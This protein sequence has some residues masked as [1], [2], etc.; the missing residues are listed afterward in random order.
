M[1]ANGRRPCMDSSHLM[2]S[3]LYIEEAQRKI[4]MLEKVYHKGY[5]EVQDD[6]LKIYG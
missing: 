2:Q 4:P 5:S 1:Y 6:G 3:I